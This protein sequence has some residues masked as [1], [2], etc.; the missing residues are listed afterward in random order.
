MTTYCPASMC[1]LI[2]PRGAPW[3]GHYNSPCLN[4]KCGWYHQGHCEGG[5]AALEQIQDVEKK[6]FTL[7]LGPTT[8]KFHKRKP[9]AYNCARALECQWQ[10]EQPTGDLC[11]PRQALAKGLDPR[12]CLY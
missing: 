3:T 11:P 7:Q 10:L 4:E 8:A 5:S 2:A 9:I 1:P 6:G 12:V